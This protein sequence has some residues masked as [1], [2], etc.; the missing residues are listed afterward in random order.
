MPS[1]SRQDPSGFIPRAERFPIRMPLHYRES[2]EGDWNEGRTLNISRSG[3]LFH[4]PR[5]VKPKTLLEMR[6]V[7]PAEILGPNPASVT[8]LGQVVR[9]EA[10]RSPDYKQA[11]AVAIRNYRIIRQDSNSNPHSTG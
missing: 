11:L 3:V 4:A 7:F 8:C 9:T 10:P 6:I 2:G 5:P 1:D